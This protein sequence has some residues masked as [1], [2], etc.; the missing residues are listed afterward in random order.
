MKRRWIVP[1]LLFAIVALVAPLASAEDKA[2]TRP[3]GS[4]E[5]RSR[6]AS[7]ELGQ[8]DSQLHG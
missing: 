3:Y 7:V 5:A 2:P 6:P 8:G 1:V 4:S